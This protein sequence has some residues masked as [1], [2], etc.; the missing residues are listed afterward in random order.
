M[1]Q[2]KLVSQESPNYIYNRIL[3]TWTWT[4]CNFPWIND[5][6]LSVVASKPFSHPYFWPV[7]Y[8]NLTSKDGII[9]LINGNHDKH[10][11]KWFT[12][13]T[14]PSNHSFLCFLILMG[15]CFFRVAIP[16]L[17]FPEYATRAG[18][19]LSPASFAIISVL[20]ALDE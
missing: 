3:L 2:K 18:V 9:Y 13:I 14:S 19:T 16:T 10:R 11:Q 20:P 15:Y 17:S 8:F 12:K 7:P 4:E 6:I 5:P 1:Y